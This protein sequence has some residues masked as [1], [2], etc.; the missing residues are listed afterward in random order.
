MKSLK[1]MADLADRFE[2]KL[3]KF[4]VSTSE[5]DTKPAV[6]DAFFEPP[7]TMGENGSERF[8]QAIKQQDSSFMKAL[9]SFG[10]K[11]FHLSIGVTVNAPGGLA[12]FIVRTTP[13]LPTAS[14]KQALIADYA[15]AYGKDPSARLKD[16]LS[17][18]QVNPPTLQA[19]VPDVIT[20]DLG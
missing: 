19:S 15:R 5:S 1:K 8:S 10:D 12:D 20:F 14:I 3:T 9:A 13:P 11:K 2:Y 7:R 6:M 18:N 4:A 17:K 16:K